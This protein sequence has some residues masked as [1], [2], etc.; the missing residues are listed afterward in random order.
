MIGHKARPLQRPPVSRLRGQ[1][2]LFDVGTSLGL[3]WLLL[4]ARLFVSFLLGGAPFGFKDKSSGSLL[5]LSLR[6]ASHRSK[7][8]LSTQAEPD[9][10]LPAL[11][12]WHGCW[13][14][15]SANSPGPHKEWACADR[16]E[17]SSSEA[18]Y[19]A[20]QGKRHQWRSALDEY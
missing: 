11:T 15:F 6:R 1:D 5:T 8:R 16:G 10:A 18:S 7:D 20:L 14:F 9:P 12:T 19:A 17:A 2:F 3:R 13:V 4:A